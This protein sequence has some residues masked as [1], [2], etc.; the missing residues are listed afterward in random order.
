MGLLLPQKPGVVA[1]QR[2]K[3]CEREGGRL[4][5]K[6]KPPLK[7]TSPIVLLLEIAAR[8]VDLLT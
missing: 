3:Q 4:E 8:A 5:K 2:M 6:G 7:Q 1:W